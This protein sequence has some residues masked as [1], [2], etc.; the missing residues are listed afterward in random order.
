MKF[1]EG[2]LSLRR[3]ASLHLWPLLPGEGFMPPSAFLF[4]CFLPL[5]LVGLR[6]FVSSLVF[7]WRL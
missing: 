4:F 3:K 6:G 1:E 5:S 2:S 7:Q